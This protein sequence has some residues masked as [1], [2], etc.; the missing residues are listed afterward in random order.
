[1]GGA[2]GG[3]GRGP[4]SGDDGYNNIGRNQNYERA[5]RPHGLGDDTWT[6]INALNR[7]NDRVRDH[8]SIQNFKNGPG[9]NGP[10][11]IGHLLNFIAGMMKQAGIKRTSR[12][13]VREIAS[14]IINNRTPNLTISNGS[15]HNPGG[16]TA[17]YDIV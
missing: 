8:G 7:F 15:L 14:A 4:G 2:G 11:A 10:G 17:S 1:M 6:D 3:G 16:S 12:G 9:Y 13:A 5:P